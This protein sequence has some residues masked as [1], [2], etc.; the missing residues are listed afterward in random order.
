MVIPLLIMTIHA[1]KKRGESTDLRALWGYGLGEVVGAD[2]LV[3]IFINRSSNQFWLAVGFANSWQL[4]ISGIYLLYNNLLTSLCVGEEW[5]HFGIERKC[6]RVSSPKGI[7]RSSYFLSLP[8]R[9]G[10]PLAIAVGLLHWLVSQSVFLV[11]AAAFLPDGTRDYSAGSYRVGYSSLGIVFSLM[12]GV[13]LIAA[14]LGLGCRRVMFKLPMVGT[15]S[16]AISAASHRPIEDD[17]AHLLPVL[18]GVV[19]A[20][21]GIKHCCLTTACD[22]AEPIQGEKYA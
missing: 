12:V 20:K 16:A 18:W 3:G 11:T 1:Q 21:D 5:S 4:E 10:I 22:V 6:L 17:D 7:Q 8:F 15:N 9:Y 19:C 13:I 14:L 2:H